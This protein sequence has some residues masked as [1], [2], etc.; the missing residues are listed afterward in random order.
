MALKDWF[1]RPTALQLA[2]KRATQPGGDLSEELRRLGDYSVNSE[3]DAKALCQILSQLR[4]REVV[5]GGWRS[6]SSLVLLFQSVSGPD[7]PAFPILKQTGIPILISIL[8]DA[9]KDESHFDRDDM[10][11]VLKI[12]AM[13]G[14]PAGTDAVIRAARWPLKSDGYWWHVVFEFYTK[15]HPETERLFRALADPLPREFIGVSLLDCANA[16]LIDGVECPHPFDTTA[17]KQQL[18]SWLTDDDEEHFSYAV[19]AVAALPFVSSPDRDR[20]LA[21]AF[22]H[23]SAQVQIEAAWAG[24]KLGGEAAV[25][26][27]GR[28]CLDVNYGVIARRY[29]TELNRR[30]AIPEIA[31]DPDFRARAEFAEWLRHPCELGRAPDELDIVDRRELRW[32]PQREPKSF[33]LIKYRVRDTTGLADDNVGVGLVGSVTFCFFSYDLDQRPPEDCYAIHCFWELEQR[34]LITHLDV[35]GSSS[36]YDHLLRDCRIEGIADGQLIEVVEIDSSLGYPQR[37]VALAGAK[38]HGHAGWIVLDGP[39]TRWYAAADMPPDQHEK[40]VTMIHVGR[41]LLGLGGD[42]D[43]PRFLRAP[44]PKRPPEQIK[45]AYERVIQDARSMASESQRFSNLLNSLRS[46]FDDYVKSVVMYDHL[47]K[48]AATVAAFESLLAAARSAQPAVRAK[49]LDIFSPIGST[50]DQ[51]IDVLIAL[52]RRDEIPS[53]IQEFRSGWDHNFGYEKLGTAAFKGGFDEI[54]EPYFL[55]LRESGKDW[56]SYE[57]IGLLANIWHRQ[58]RVEDARSILVEAMHDLLEQS[59]RAT[60][61][62]RK[63]FEEWF[64]NHRSAFLK[65][66][67]NSGE[68]DLRAHGIPPSTDRQ[69]E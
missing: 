27:L 33:W 60:G 39:R 22:D 56:C 55:L 47:P 58:G 61:G 10:L 2:L 20:L 4:T 65:L 46:S 13:Y 37:M 59:A 69:P 11:F 31:A 32:P 44:G 6:S 29:L 50:F 38:K 52:K 66:V 48:D 64:Q 63:R 1:S 51:Y 25:R 9:L 21:I 36:E 15:D 54:A 28:L 17:G 7:C 23:P 42:S 40:V 3:A 35:E 5:V 19:S 68:N 62:D 18:E 14:T 57:E 12:L 49:W 53:L 24:A 67:G 43:R 30:D 26:F 41:E 34:R 45:A 8:D 16:A